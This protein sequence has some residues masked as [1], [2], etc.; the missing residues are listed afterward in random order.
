MSSKNVKS[1]PSLSTS[2][3]DKNP[4]RPNARMDENGAEILSNVSR[5]VTVHLP[6]MG[7]RIRRYLKSPQSQQA[8]Y[9]DPDLWDDENHE[10]VF[11][12]NGIRHTHSVH[13][14]RYKEGIEEAKKRKTAR[15]KE[16]KEAEEAQE[17]ER[18]EARRNEIKQLIKEGQT[19]DNIADNT[20]V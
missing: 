20:T 19:P 4:I 16:A 1:D 17:K 13:E 12:D 8:L 15:D 9:E 10:A 7:E 3:V 5:T 6:S 18:K 14:D 11:D 2:I